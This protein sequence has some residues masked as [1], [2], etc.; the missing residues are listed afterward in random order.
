MEPTRSRAI[1][2]LAAD[3][4]D[5]GAPT[6]TAACR[7]AGFATERPS[8][9]TEATSSIANNANAPRTTSSATTAFAYQVSSLTF[10]L[11]PRGE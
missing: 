5:S 2:G 9:A 7:N 8:A 11:P 3:Q 4:T 1:V 6:A 10:Q